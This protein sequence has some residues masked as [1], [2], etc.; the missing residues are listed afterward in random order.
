MDRNVCTFAS[1]SVSRHG[2]SGL[3]LI[4]TL[5]MLIHSLAAFADGGAAIQHL[6]ARGG[7]L[8]LTLYHGNLS[9]TGL[10]IIGAQREDFQHDTSTLEVLG[11]DSIGFQADSGYFTELEGGHL[12][13][14]S[15]L[16]ISANGV[17]VDSSDLHL[18]PR[19]STRD[20]LLLID[21]RGSEWFYLDY[22]HYER[23]DRWLYAR[24]L[25]MRISPTLA[26]E[27]GDPTLAGHIVGYATLETEIDVQADDPQGFVLSCPVEDPNW[28]T[29]DGYAGDVAMLKLPVVS[30]IAR[31]DGRV[32]LA[33]S[34]YFENIGNADI[35]WFAQFADSRGVDECCLDQ[36]EG[37][38]APYG[39]DQGGLLVLSLIHISE[40]TRPPVASRMPSS[41]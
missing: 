17:Q 30:Q 31:L 40:P 20:T 10:E 24:Y 22:G 7:K 25:D 29:R 37:L 23:L 6:S 14:G 39:N 5:I 3:R 38:C 13:L 35:P 18:V 4:L 32:A 41:A 15:G 28:P 19:E 26:Q 21:P 11:E 34:A 27:L 16:V 1:S 12:S 8:S 2:V 36:G 9:G 33:P